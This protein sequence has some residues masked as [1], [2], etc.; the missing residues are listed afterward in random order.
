IEH[1]HRRTLLAELQQQEQQDDLEEA[2]LTATLAEAE[3]RLHAHEYH[4]LLLAAQQAHRARHEF[5]VYRKGKQAGEIREAALRHVPLDLER[6]IDAVQ[7]ELD[8]T[9]ATF[10]RTFMDRP[11][12]AG[13]RAN[14]ER[15]IAELK[16][17]LAELQALRL[18]L[19]YQETMAAVVERLHLL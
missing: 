2:D 17:G 5:V 14:L 4:K 19:D 16:S 10:A 13:T 15:R 7:R 3:R 18:V 1:D 12:P 8:E 11:P 9:S 6:A